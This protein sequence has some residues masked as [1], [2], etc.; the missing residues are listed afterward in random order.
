MVASGG[1]DRSASPA[2]GGQ[3]GARRP[4]R[5]RWSPHVIL[6]RADGGGARRA[7]H[8][9]RSGT[10]PERPARPGCL[11]RAAAHRP[12][13]WWA[14]GPAARGRAW[15]ASLEAHSTTSTPPGG[16]LVHPIAAALV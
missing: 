15:R 7:A 16:G 6:S 8:G 11:A 12:S 13:S 5:I 14:V 1:R 9:A 3:Q 2:E 4:D 10:E